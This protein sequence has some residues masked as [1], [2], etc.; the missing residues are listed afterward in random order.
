MSNIQTKSGEPTFGI[1]K[2]T[3][4]MVEDKHGTRAVAY[5]DDDT[6]WEGHHGEGTAIQLEYPPVKLID[7]N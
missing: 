5:H 1:A 2:H 7:A 3:T 6:W 4:V